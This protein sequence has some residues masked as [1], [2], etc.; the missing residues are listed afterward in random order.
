MCPRVIAR[1]I[2]GGT[3]SARGSQTR[4]DLQTL[5]ATWAAQGKSALAQCYA[6]LVNPALS[7]LQ[8]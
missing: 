7:L 8:V 3:R 4:M 5:F 2:S 1:K 6:M